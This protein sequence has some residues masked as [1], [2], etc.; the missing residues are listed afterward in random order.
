MSDY[1]FP[2]KDVEFL[3]N[4]VL[5][6]DRRCADAGLDEINAE[7]ALAILDEAGR[8]G[9]E[10]LGPS[11]QRL[12]TMVYTRPRGLPMPTANLSIMAGPR[13]PGMRNMAARQCPGS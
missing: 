5:D 3:L 1:R 2:Y 4:H 10:V 12:Q 9:S 8:L 6:F 11:A 7:L 13:S